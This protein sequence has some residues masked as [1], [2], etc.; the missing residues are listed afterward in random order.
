[1]VRGEERR[2]LRLA[3]SKVLGMDSGREYIIENLGE[4][5]LKIA[6]DLLEEMERT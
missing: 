5:Y 2:V 6:Q 4:D 1:M 3:L